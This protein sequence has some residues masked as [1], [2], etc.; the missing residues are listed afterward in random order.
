VK[1]KGQAK[2]QMMGGKG[3]YKPT[4]GKKKMTSKK[5]GK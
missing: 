4:S 1:S 5:K 3:N 2:M